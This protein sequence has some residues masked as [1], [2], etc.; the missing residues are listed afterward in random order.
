MDLELCNYVSIDSALTVKH[1]DEKEALEI[2][3]SK[4][5]LKII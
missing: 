3:T 4:S 2:I 1:G 5:P